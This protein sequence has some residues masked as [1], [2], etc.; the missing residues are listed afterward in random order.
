MKYVKLIL[1][2]LLV[3]FAYDLLLI[4]NGFISFGTDGIANVFNYAFGYNVPLLLIIIN[5][6]IIAVSLFINSDNA[7][8]Y[9]YSSLLIPLFVFL[10]SF[11]NVPIE[12]PEKVLVIVICGLFIGFGYDL[13]FHSGFKVGTIFLLEEDLGDIT[14]IYTKLYSV[15]IDVIIVL[16]VAFSKSHIVAIY[17]IFIIVIARYIANKARFNLHDSKMFYVITDKDKEIKEY[18]LKTLGY[19]LTELDV[20]GGFSKEKKS[21]LLSVIAAKDYFK[22]KT[23]IMDIDSDAFVAI[24]DTYDVLNR[25]E[26]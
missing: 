22:L 9:L 25:K 2:S 19:E 1:G 24:T 26:F 18:I 4:P 8:K 5:I 3:A 7:F 14:G 11:I 20:K 10:L 17:S 12:L 16:I 23:G 21:I 6:S 13:V 15:I